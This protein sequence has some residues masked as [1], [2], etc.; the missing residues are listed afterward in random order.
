MIGY[1]QY[2]PTK[3]ALRGLAESLRQELLPYGIEV[4]IYY[5]ATIDS[6]GNKT[7][8]E[9]KPSITKLIEEGDMSDHSPASRA[10]T[11]LNGIKRGYFAISS[12]LLTDLFR[13]ASLGATPGNNYIIDSIQAVIS[14][15]GIPIW[16]FYADHL[17]LKSHHD[18]R[19]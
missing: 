1:S 17:V 19:G 18:K 5:V 13:T 10:T 4:H 9:T 15:I 8:N 16:R 2:S 7:E 11:L 14:R 6:P 3:F 12:D